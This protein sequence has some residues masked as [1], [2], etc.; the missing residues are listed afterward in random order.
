MDLQPKSISNN[1][2]NNNVVGGNDIIS[3]TDQNA[4]KNSIRNILTQS[5]YLVPNIGVNL[6]S[7]IGRDI[8]EGTARAIGNA[9]DRG[10]SLY[11]PRVKLE[12]LIVAGNEDKFLYNIILIISFPNFNSSQTVLEA[13]LDNDGN[14]QY[15]NKQ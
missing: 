15:I 5:R 14:F 7:F 9:I 3:D 6:K 11:E 2:R 13:I 4:I 1:K 12:K 10:I 8:S